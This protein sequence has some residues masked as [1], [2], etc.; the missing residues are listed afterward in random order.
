VAPA[1]TDA[2]AA[3]P[4]LEREEDVAAVAGGSLSLLFVSELRLAL[5][6]STTLSYAKALSM[7]NTLSATADSVA[8]RTAK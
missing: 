8:H 2:D 6:G 1:P 7:Q 4:R 5:D 3:L